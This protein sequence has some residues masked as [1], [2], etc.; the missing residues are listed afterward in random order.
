MAESND[1]AECTK[2]GVLEELSVP[3]LI[4][5]AVSMIAI[6]KFQGENLPSQ[7]VVEVAGVAESYM[8]GRGSHHPSSRYI[9]VQGSN[10]RNLDIAVH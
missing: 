5:N 9:E 10:D 4:E 3:S 2:I 8:S 7:H 6:S 1:Q